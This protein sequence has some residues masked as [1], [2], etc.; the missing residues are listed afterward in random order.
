MTG[1]L[2]PLEQQFP[3]VDPATGRPTIYFI[4]WAQQRQIDIT[5]GITA[6]QAQQLILDFMAAHQLQEGLGISITPSGN[7][8]DDPT[9]AL[10]AV[11][12][13]LQDVDTETTPPTDGQALV[14]D[15]ADQLWV[16]GDVASGGG[17]GS[18]QQIAQ[19]ELTATAAN[20]DFTNIPQEYDDLVLVIFGRGT[21]AATLINPRIQF[22][23]DTAA[24]YDGEQI[25]S[26]SSGTNFSQY[27]A[28]T[29]GDLGNLP[30]STADANRAGQAVVN[31][32]NYSRAGFMKQVLSNWN[33]SYSTGGFT[34]G[35]GQYSVTWRDTAAINRI[36]LT[37]SAGSFAAGTVATLYGRG[38]APKTWPG[39]V[40]KEVICAGGETEVIITDIPQT[41]RD[42]ILN[43]TAGMQGGGNDVALS[44]QFNGDTGNNYA[45]QQ[46]FIN[47]GGLTG[48][49]SSGV[50]SIVWMQATG[51]GNAL[52]DMW[53]SGS[54]QIG[55]YAAGNHGKTGYGNSWNRDGDTREL[56]YS[57]EWRS[58][59]PLTSLRV[60]P[61]ISA[62][63]AGTKITLYGIGGPGGQTIYARPWYWSPPVASGFALQS[64]DANQLQL[65][66]D[67]DVGLLVNGNTPVAGDVQRFAYRTLTNPAADWSM[68]A[69]F[70][71]EMDPTNF[72]LLGL[73]MRDQ[74]GGRNVSWD[75]ASDGQVRL[76]RARFNGMTGFNSSIQ[77][78]CVGMQNWLR[79]DRVGANLLHYVSVDGKNWRLV[80]TEAVTAWMANAPQRVGLFVN[81][82]RTVAPVLFSVDYFSLTGPAV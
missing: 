3:I 45:H 18:L 53:A 61:A 71:W 67:A 27:T 11:L 32:S 78:N 42:L 23:G 75:W 54:F 33:A 16:P 74:T 41:F 9:I 39:N 34:Q 35:N 12:D 79:V 56:T 21:Q 68:I 60:F 10:N 25:H 26:Y 80:V 22:N 36:L 69:R 65:I 73:L 17:G 1:N 37:P 8:A 51:N 31:I 28:Q 57:G 7:L 44:L 30:G 77:V 76:Q 58:N 4:K 24:N 20:I 46:L 47:G 70:N 64:G 48:V 59:S 19:F 15:D 14:W 66:D 52:P 5:A 2:Q 6:E 43:V 63:K 40:I 55:D 38:P 72:A 82:N 49:R 13:D 81:Y 29:S 50:S 62:F